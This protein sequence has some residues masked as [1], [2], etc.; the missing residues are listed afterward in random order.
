[1][2][3]RSFFGQT[4]QA[5]PGDIG[6]PYP[7]DDEGC[8]E[9]GSEIVFAGARPCCSVCDWSYDDEDCTVEE[10]LAGR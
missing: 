7:E 10:E 5:G 2:T 9:C 1:V 8:P 6:E 3:G 4:I